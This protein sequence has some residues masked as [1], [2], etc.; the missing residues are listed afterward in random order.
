M[1]QSR[2]RRYGHCLFQRLAVGLLRISGG[3]FPP[4]Q[5]RVGI[6]GVFGIDHRRGHILH[7]QGYESHHSGR[8]GIRRLRSG[9]N[10]VGVRRLQWGSDSR[11]GYSCFCVRCACGTHGERSAHARNRW[12]TVPS[13]CPVHRLLRGDPA[14]ERRGGL[15]GAGLRHDLER[16]S[17]GSMRRRRGS[18]GTH[19]VELACSAWPSRRASGSC[20][21]RTSSLTSVPP[22]RLD[23]NNA[24]PRPPKRPGRPAELCTARR[25]GTSP[26]D[27]CPRPIGTVDAFYLPAT[28]PCPTARWGRNS[29]P[30]RLA[31]QQAGGRIVPGAW[32]LRSVSGGHYLHRMTTHSKPLTVLLTDP[33]GRALGLSLP[34]AHW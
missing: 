17:R 19:R 33:M 16:D 29:S 4:T 31:T 21:A 20:R 25:T 12:P 24:K 34:P 32:Q 18:R 13:A 6:A 26:V 27:A 7:F 15:A 23:C 1:G 5:N 22:G 14:I 8:N 9:W 10:G 30:G 3:L 28:G 2:L 11:V